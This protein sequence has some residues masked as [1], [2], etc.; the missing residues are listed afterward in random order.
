MQSDK[1]REQKLQRLVGIFTA[2]GSGAEQGAGHAVHGTVVVVVVIVVVVV[3]L[4]VVY[5]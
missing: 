4:V 2:V 5:K 3:V 1:N